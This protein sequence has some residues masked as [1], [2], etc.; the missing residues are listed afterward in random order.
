MQNVLLR[1][2][3]FNFPVSVTEG[4]GER[5]GRCIYGLLYWAESLFLSTQYEN[6]FSPN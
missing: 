2:S 1:P 5:E 4:G 6:I 3:L